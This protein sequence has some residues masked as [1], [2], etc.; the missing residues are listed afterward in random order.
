MLR[1][2]WWMVVAGVSAGVPALAQNYP[3][4]PV[5]LIVLFPPGGSTET[6]ARMLSVRLAQL[7]GQQ[8]IIE[9]RPG[10]GRQGGARRLY[11]AHGVG[12]AAH[13]RSRVSDQAGL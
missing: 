12:R 2:G 5:R 7:W 11:P 6:L 9:N 13:H 1:Y 8:I 3:A 4:K 10:A